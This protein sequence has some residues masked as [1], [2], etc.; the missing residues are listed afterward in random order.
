MTD[1]ERTTATS[2]WDGFTRDLT[3]RLVALEDGDFVL[4]EADKPRETVSR[5]Q[6]LGGLIPEKRTPAKPYVQCL[7]MEDHLHLEC[8]GR[9]EAGGA[10][11]WA[12]DE[13]RLLLDLGWDVADPAE[14]PSGN[15]VRA[16]R[17]DDA[18]TAARLMVR[19][20]REAMGCSTPA[21]VTLDPA[22]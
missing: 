13:H 9:P 14:G 2:G 11:P 17:R 21:E 4:A 6:R 20:L 10:F 16:L 19:T 8:I 1:P 15:Y 22:P 7:R 3:G 18:T 12:A 5:R